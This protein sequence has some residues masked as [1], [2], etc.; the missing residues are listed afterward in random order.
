[1][2]TSIGIDIVETAR[3]DRLLNTYGDR[4]VDRILGSREKEMLRHRKD[5]AQF[6]AGRFACKEAVIKALG[7]YLTERPAYSQIEIVGDHSSGPYASINADIVKGLGKARTL[8]SISHEKTH[9][10]ALAV[11][12]EEK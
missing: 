7:S 8:V 9:A 5:T 6:L 1:M 12:S 10:V 11:I 3:V 2:V 4:F